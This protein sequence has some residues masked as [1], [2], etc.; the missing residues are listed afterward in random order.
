MSSISPCSAELNFGKH[1][2]SV[3]SSGGKAFP[4][5]LEGC[6]CR[7]A[8]VLSKFHL[9]IRGVFCR[10]EG[11]WAGRDEE[12]VKEGRLAGTRG[13][14]CGVETREECGSWKW[15]GLDLGIKGREKEAAECR[16]CRN[17]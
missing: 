12:K 5:T 2:M 13:M 3:M 14:K 16:S 10:S 9:E 8:Q 15:K 4:C 7:W 17:R 6:V 11:S 1:I